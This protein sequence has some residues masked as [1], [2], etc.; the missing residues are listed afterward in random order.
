MTGGPCAVALRR[1]GRQRLLRVC[2]PPDGRNVPYPAVITTMASHWMSRLA[3]RVSFSTVR[4]AGRNAN[5]GLLHETP[6]KP[7]FSRMGNAVSPT[8]SSL[9]FKM[10]R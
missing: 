3:A 8:D 1:Q 10:T 2:L 5:H 6:L 9:R 7:E 4:R